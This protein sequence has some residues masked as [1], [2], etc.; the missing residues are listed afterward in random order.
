M[1]ATVTPWAAVMC[2][3]LGAPLM[4]GNEGCE[5]GSGLPTGNDLIVSDPSASAGGGNAVAI[6]PNGW[7]VISYSAYDGAAHTLRVARC[8]GPDCTQASISV[9]DSELSGGVDTSIAIGADGLPLIVYSAGGLRAAHCEDPTCSAARVSLLETTAFS[10]GHLSLAIGSDG[11][12]LISFRDALKGELAVA[13][14]EDVAC[15]AATVSLLADA[16]G[17]GRNSVLRIGSDGLGLIGHYDDDQGVRVARCVDI[18]CTAAHFSTI[19]RGRG[20]FVHGRLG[21]AMGIDGLPLLAYD[22]GRPGGLRTAHCADV[23][24]SV[25]DGLS[26]ST[27]SDGGWLRCLDGPRLR[28]PG[29]DRVPRSGRPVDRDALRGREVREFCVHSSDRRRLHPFHWHWG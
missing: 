14:C 26:P 11:L 25:V 22:H 20:V 24:C 23:A 1:K 12:G 6:A 10:V 19:E 29:A 2:A 18:A 28:R 9:I 3:V 27:G 7:P 21:L 16:P 5:G 17:P 8:Q 4:L 13:H 15:T